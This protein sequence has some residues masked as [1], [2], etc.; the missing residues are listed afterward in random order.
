MSFLFNAWYVGAWADEVNRT[1]LPRTILDERVVLYRKMDG[2]AA[3]IGGVCPHRFAP[4]HLGRLVDDN[5]Q[6]GYHG[7]QFDCS[8]KCV[9]SPIDPKI[10]SAAKVKSYPLIEKFGIIWIWMGEAQAADESKIP[11]FSYLLD[12]ARKVLSG[13]MTVQANYELV[14]DNLADLTHT[15]FLHG[16]F[17]HTEALPNAKHEVIQ[18]GDTIYSKFWFPNG[19]VPPLMGEYMDNADLVVDRWTEI[20]W[21]PPA[22]IRLDAGATPTGQPREAGIQAYG[23][24]LLTPETP[25][26]THYFYA[27]ARAFKI[28]DDAT[29]KLVREWQRVAFNEQDK[30]VIEAQ[31]KILGDRNLMSMHP[32]LLSC[33]AGGM[34]IRRTLKKLIEA[35]QMPATDP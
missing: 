13:V 15:H 7:L 8:G 31:Q 17:L 22:T 21:D 6:C 28:D 5:V 12:P 14:V 19:R 33:D 23:T 9:V 26:S 27:H 3:A 29:D 35:D 11:D 25:S 20:R 10:P 1:L 24:H 4:L 34:R 32:V 16:N 18:D 30:P 2:T